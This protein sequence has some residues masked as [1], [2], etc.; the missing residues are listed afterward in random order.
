ML[1][2][3]LAG[4][5]GT[6]IGT[7]I[8]GGVAA[9][10]VGLLEWDTIVDWF[11]RDKIKSVAKADEDRIAVVIKEEMKGGKVPVIQG[12]FDM[13]AEE[14]LEAEVYEAEELDADLRRQLRTNEP[15]IYEYAN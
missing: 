13:E 14:F 1:S 10:V 3:I 5:L 4:I 11:E 7:L 8:G 2:I 12:I 6:L 9:L 15:L